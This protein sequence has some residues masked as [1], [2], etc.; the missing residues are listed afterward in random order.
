[1][2]SFQSSPL[3][4]GSLTSLRLPPDGRQLPQCR[5]ADSAFIL[6]PSKNRWSNF[7]PLLQKNDL[8][9]HMPATAYSPAANNILFGGWR[10]GRTRIAREGKSSGILLLFIR[11]DRHYGANGGTQNP[12]RH[13][14][15][16]KTFNSRSAVGT[17]H[18]HV[19]FFFRRGV[20]NGF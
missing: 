14:A 4:R 15:D 12:F 5:T 8:A 18:N 10:M 6:C 3:N 13:I 16:Q 1:M 17:H 20:D 2:I 19:G 11:A 9:R 7:Q